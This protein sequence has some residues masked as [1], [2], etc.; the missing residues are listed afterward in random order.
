MIAPTDLSQVDLFSGL[1]PEDLAHF[2]RKAADVRLR[3]DDWLVREGERSGFYVVLKG[4]LRF[5]KDIHGKDYEVH[6]NGPGDFFGEMPNILGVLSGVSAQAKTKCRLARFELQQLQEL[7]DES[8]SSSQPILSKMLQRVQMAQAYVQSTP[9]A[10][11]VII[12]RANVNTKMAVKIRMFLAGNRIPY[13]WKKPVGDTAGKNSDLMVV[14]DGVQHLTNPTVRELAE[15]FGFQIHPRR[16]SYDLIVVGAGPAGMAAAVYAASEGLTV[17]VA[18]RWHAG[19]Q[20]GTSSRISNYLGFPGGISGDDL[21]ARAL[22]QASWFGA[23]ITMTRTAET[24][25]RE[26]PGY[27]VSLDGGERVLARSVLLATGVE[28]RRLEMEGL[29][30]YLGRGVLYGA[31]RTEATGVTGRK[32][33]IVGGGNSAG[34]AAMFF[35]DYADEV[36]L[37][38]RGEGLASSMSHYLIDQLASKRNIAVEPFT[39][40]TSVGGENGLEHIVTTTH[41]PGKEPQV[42]TRPADALYIMIG[43]KANTAWLPAEI[44]RDAKGFVCT[45]RDVPAT[46]GGRT[47]FPL[48]T[49]L[50][51]VFCAGDVRYGSIKRVASGVGEGSMAVSFIHQYL[52]LVEAEQ[53]VASRK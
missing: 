27:C 4:N 14:V 26:G 13:R 6:V 41:E 23:E 15:A 19:G 35:A 30:E 50:D 20:A 47:P 45:G 9:A 11:A 38:V 34:Q 18:E 24:V 51:G 33:F 48:E 52:A 36:R 8:R 16:A 42:H 46:T 29:H 17:L 25:T 1:S 31:A 44:K 53:E 37:L 5:V 28:W 43:A 21:T 12:G 40:V 7:I 2:A 39:Q 10:R 32:V 49:S 3:P 22:K